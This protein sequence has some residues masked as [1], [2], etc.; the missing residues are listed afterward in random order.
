M[1]SVYEYA[2]ALWHAIGDMT[3]CA[4]LMSGELE[5][6]IDRFGCLLVSKH[7]KF[8]FENVNERVIDS[9]VTV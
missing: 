1:R 9:M 8:K 6:W 5:E 3:R 4:L 7:V 2:S